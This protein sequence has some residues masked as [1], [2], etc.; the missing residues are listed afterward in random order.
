MWNESEDSLSN[1]YLNQN[2]PAVLLGYLRPIV[3]MITAASPFS[4]YNL[5][6]INF[7]E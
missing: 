3:A 2:A 6:L 7:R 4:A 1:I 5:P